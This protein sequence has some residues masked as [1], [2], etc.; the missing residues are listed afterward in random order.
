MQYNLMARAVMST[1]FAT[2]VPTYQYPDG[3]P[4]TCLLG[5][6]CITRI[7]LLPA[8]TRLQLYWWHCG[9]SLLVSL[10]CFRW[11]AHVFTS[12]NVPIEMINLA[13][14]ITRGY[15]LKPLELFQSTL[16]SNDPELFRLWNLQRL[17]I[18]VN[19]SAPHIHHNSNNSHDHML[20]LALVF[21]PMVYR[22][23]SLASDIEPVP[24]PQRLQ[25]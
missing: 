4:G 11:W 12:Y 13:S 21:G 17:L 6:I 15:D 1:H 9:I 8:G 20:A 2:R 22:E 10:T 5:S 23:D 14:C 16:N 18:F 7:A 24:D 19:K 3:Y 25:L